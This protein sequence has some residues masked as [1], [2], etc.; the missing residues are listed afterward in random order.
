MFKLI[1]RDGA[2]ENTGIHEGIE[3]AV[4]LKRGQAVSISSG[5]AVVATDGDVYGI[6]AE[7]PIDG[8]VTVLKATPDMIFRCPATANAAKGLKV[9]LATGAE[10]VTATAVASGKYGATIVENLEGGFAEVRFE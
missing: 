1:L 10:G 7:E 5:K 2:P 8:I 9:T 6:V 3:T 4:T